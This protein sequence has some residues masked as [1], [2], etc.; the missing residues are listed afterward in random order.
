MEAV[1]DC[2]KVR[3]LWRVA[4]VHRRCLILIKVLLDQKAICSVSDVILI[5]IIS[6]I[7][8]LSLNN[9][10]FIFL[11]GAQLRALQLRELVLEQP[12]I[13][14]C[15]I[16]TQRYLRD[17]IVIITRNCNRFVV[18]LVLVA[19][20]ERISSRIRNWLFLCSI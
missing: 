11:S 5:L 17:H 20:T 7:T 9:H 16:V 10:D 1:L 8:Y 18:F 19:N 15:R 6:I 2:R 4:L 14:R 12:P 3:E 13:K